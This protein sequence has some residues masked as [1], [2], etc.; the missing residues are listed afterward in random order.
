MVE[1]YLLKGKVVCGDC[2]SN[3]WIKG[4]GKVDK[5]G[6]VYRYYYCNDRERKKKYDKKFDKE[7]IEFNKRFNLLKSLI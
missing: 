2:G 4:G 7:V 5:E 6:N 3:M 1:N